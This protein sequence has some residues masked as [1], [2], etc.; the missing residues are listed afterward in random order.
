[1][2]QLQWATC[3]AVWLPSQWTKGK[4]QRDLPMQATQQQQ[5]LPIQATGGLEFDHRVKRNSLMM[6]WFKNKLLL[7]PPPSF[8]NNSTTALCL[9]IA[10]LRL[11][12]PTL[13][14]INCHGVLAPELAPSPT[15]FS[16]LSILLI[17]FAL[18]SAFLGFFL[19]F[20]FLFWLKVVELD[21]FVKSLDCSSSVIFVFFFF[22]NGN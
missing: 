10:L 9:S 1:M 12:T 7:L 21:G 14:R 4:P 11:G 15:L 16:S 17:R 19:S 6:L 8:Y 3:V 20:S 22:G 13:R 2:Q 5:C 18:A